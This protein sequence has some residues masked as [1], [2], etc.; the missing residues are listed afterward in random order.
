MKEYLVDPDFSN[1]QRMLEVDCTFNT[2][3]DADNFI[4]EIS[5]EGLY[6]LF[7]IEGHKGAW[8]VTG[9]ITVQLGEMPKAIKIIENII[10]KY[11]THQFIDCAS[12]SYLDWNIDKYSDYNV[13]Q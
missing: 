2:S 7:A 4:N 5:R 13:N 3:K 10:N 8:N 12:T 9:S 6:Y 11:H 1:S